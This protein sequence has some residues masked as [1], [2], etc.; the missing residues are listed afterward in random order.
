M[1]LIVVLYEVHVMKSS[2]LWSDCASVRSRN[3]N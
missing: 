3:I 2:I 1:Y